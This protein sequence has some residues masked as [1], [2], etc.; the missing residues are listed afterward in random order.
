LPSG[1]TA[2]PSGAAEKPAKPVAVW[3]RV[4][5]LTRLGREGPVQRAHR[6]NAGA[7]ELFEELLAYS[8]T[9]GATQPRIDYFATS[10][11]A[12]LLFEDD[13]AAPRQINAM[14]L[15]AQAQLGFAEHDRASD[16]LRE[17]LRHDPSHSLA[18]DLLQEISTVSHAE[19]VRA[20]AI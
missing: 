9:L 12:M 10:L 8:K 16:L 13:L 5:A 15:D 17:I 4:R 7:D 6:G 18:A 3:R 11:P 1:G 20:A 2:L 19:P 14:L